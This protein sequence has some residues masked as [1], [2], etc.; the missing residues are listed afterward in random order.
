MRFG[1]IGE[2]ANDP[3]VKDSGTIDLFTK[4]SCHGFATEQPPN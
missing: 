1:I 2:P 3:S 4:V